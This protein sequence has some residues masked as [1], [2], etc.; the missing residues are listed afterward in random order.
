MYFWSWCFSLSKMLNAE[1]LPEYFLQHF[2]HTAVHSCLTDDLTT[3]HFSTRSSGERHLRICA[4][5]SS[6]SQTVSE[7]FPLGVLGMNDTATD[8]APE[9]KIYKLTTTPELQNRSR[10]SN[11]SYGSN[12]R[13][14]KCINSL[15][16]FSQCF[17]DLTPQSSTLRPLCQ[18]WG[19]HISCQGPLESLRVTKALQPSHF[20]YQSQSAS[21]LLLG[22]NSGDGGQQTADAVSLNPLPASA[23]G[24][25]AVEVKCHGASRCKTQT[26]CH[27]PPSSSFSGRMTTDKLASSRRPEV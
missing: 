18:Q 2:L 10:Q 8:Y 21:Y 3:W 16:L 22:L 20:R 4:R 27:T 24:C 14:K 15:C 6:C 13:K 19:Q 7:M 11:R 26:D 5:T 17:A 12:T 1:L 25:M 9:T 23:A